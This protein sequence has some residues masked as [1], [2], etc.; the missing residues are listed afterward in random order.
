MSIRAEK[1]L[2]TLWRRVS[3]RDEG[4][5]AL[6]IVIVVIV[7][8]TGFSVALANQSDEQAPISTQSVLGRLALQ[9][10]Q[11]GLADYQDFI[12]ANPLNAGS[13][14]SNSTFSC[15]QQSTTVTS[16]SVPG[17]ITVG[18]TTGFNL[19]YLIS[20]TTT[21]GSQM[22]VSCTGS[23]TTTFTGCTGNETT[24]I[25]ASSA[26]L[27]DETPG[28]EDPAFVSAFTATPSCTANT[29]SNQWSTATVSN[30]AGTQAAYQ[31]VV[32]SSALYSSTSG[33]T[34]SG[35]E[36]YVY[37]TG[38]AGHSGDYRCASVQGS[39]WVQLAEPGQA[40]TVVTDDNYTAID[41]PSGSCGANC[42][43][44]TVTFTVSGAQGGNGGTGFLGTGGKGGFGEEIEG[45]F[46]I[47]SSTQLGTD[48]GY[49]G[50]MAGNNVDSTTT[51]ASGSNNVSL[52]ANTID[53]ASTS[54]FTMPLP[55]YVTTTSNNATTQQLVTCDRKLSSTAFTNCSGGAGT[56][57]TGGAVTQ[58]WSTGYGN[59]GASGNPG[60]SYSYGGGYSSSGSGGA[61]SAVCLEPLT[62]GSCT[63]ST[64][65][66]NGA[67]TSVPAAPGCVL[68]VAAG[69]GGAGEGTSGGSAGNGGNGGGEQVAFSS[70][71]TPT[72]S[73]ATAEA[74]ADV[75]SSGGDGYSFFG[76]NTTA[77]GGGKWTPAGPSETGGSR[78]TGESIFGDTT[79]DGSP[80]Q[81]N[82]G[83]SGA[84]VT[85]TGAT[86]AENG[87]NGPAFSG[88]G[89]FWWCTGSDGGGGGGGLAGGGSGAA[90]GDGGAGAGAGA[91]SWFDAGAICSSST[92]GATN[93][94]KC[95]NYSA[96]CN[97]GSCL[98][99]GTS[100]SG[101]NG[102]YIY[103]GIENIVGGSTI[104]TSTTQCLNSGGGN[105]YTACSPPFASYPNWYTGSS[106]TVCGGSCVHYGTPET[107][108]ASGSN[109]LTL[110]QS[111]IDVASTAGFNLQYPLDV[112]LNTG[113]Y[114][115]VNCTGTTGTTFT[116]CSGGSGK[117]DS[118]SGLNNV[119][120]DIGQLEACGSQFDTEAPPATTSGSI[121]MYGGGGG[122]AY[123]GGGA[124]GNGGA[125]TVNFVATAADWY[126]VELGCG[127]GGGG[128]SWK[129]G[130]A[131]GCTVGASG[132]CA[133]TTNGGGGGGGA[134]WLCFE[135]ASQT[136]CSVGTAEC[137]TSGALTAPCLLA[138]V[139]G[140]GG[141]GTGGGPGGGESSSTSTCTATAPVSCN[142]YPGY[143]GATESGAGAAGNSWFDSGNAV[144]GL[145]SVTADDNSP[146]DFPAWGTTP[147]FECTSSSTTVSA[148]FEE[149]VDN[150]QAGSA[151]TVPTT[152]EAG[153]G[154]G[155]YDPTG[156][157]S[158][159]AGF[160]GYGGQLGLVV[161][162]GEYP[163]VANYGWTFWTVST[164][165]LESGAC[166]Y[167]PSA[168]STYLDNDN[169][170]DSTTVTLPNSGTYTLGVG[171]GAGAN[172]W[173]TAGSGDFGTG[174]SG[175][176]L[177]FRVPGLSAG[178]QLTVVAG[179]AGFGPL[180]GIGFSDGGSSGFQPQGQVAPTNTIN[181]T[182]FLNGVGGG[183]GGSSA[184][185]L[186]PSG[187]SNPT[188]TENT[189]LCT[190][191]SPTTTCLIALAGGGG[192]GGTEC[193]AQCSTT[194]PPVL[195]LS[196]DC[197]TT[198]PDLAGEG[199]SSAT[200]ATNWTGYWDGTSYS[201]NGPGTSYTGAAGGGGGATS[202]APQSYDGDNTYP[203]SPSG[204]NPQN[205]GNGGWYAGPGYPN[206][207]STTLGGIG[208]GGGGAGF[209]GGWADAWAATTSGPSVPTD[210]NPG[211]TSGSNAYLTTGSAAECGAGGGSS[212]VAG[213]VSNTVAGSNSQ[214]N[215]TIQVFFDPPGQSQPTA[216]S[217]VPVYSTTW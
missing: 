139:G 96:S 121:Y 71:A 216:T 208:A 201:A 112:Q 157:G 182:P 64:P 158:A 94:S 5:Q 99:I 106:H 70:S 215:G 13:F 108:I 132:S 202:G 86:V 168:S 192:G 194:T 61:G 111:T 175:S 21:S 69:G 217:Q 134:S 66:C 190:T 41:V 181:F 213:I 211:A 74:D 36:V 38:R 56:M 133:A 176:E 150:G 34:P 184:I 187:V 162:S 104:P 62:G 126:G 117:L 169:S 73:P 72:T 47:P 161:V 165:A 9:A 210:A 54:G 115:E 11:A 103:G 14:C 76:Q 129:G 148:D 60:G 43:S 119:F 123:N 125:A 17:T 147:K 145:T 100:S 185:C 152:G 88:D 20:V 6:A 37:A 203:D 207:V 116:G 93:A 82:S 120:E 89:C 22:S 140:G 163:Y 75:G 197:T 81:P 177:T 91:A 18:S 153:A 79:P 143:K 156:T 30:V 186:S 2:R 144:Y 196:T 212:W 49:Q 128:T 172:G 137:S 198:S 25:L 12:S 160:G 10:A 40:Q 199:L 42:S 7:L 195:N 107:T 164:P 98:Q 59:G 151:T 51:I 16:G 55:I 35:G 63:S 19:S 4:G 45:T 204:G 102:S 87:A 27:Q 214:T 149:S 122:G 155:G 130:A 191:N 167:T 205:G 50:V 24:S 58:A 39:F 48:L 183:G 90:G 97:T 166:N 3:R 84:T 29:T 92:V 193:A 159:G 127:G 80:G 105:A 154:C 110:P 67:V 174:G 15:H 171:G 78:G 31:Y 113:G 178:Q 77:A 53:V 46:V 95:P 101:G 114:T 173:Q 135:G 32:N 65:L 142:G 33:S 57:S 44:T 189:P 179:C 23:T 83:T 209:E 52:P 26:A 118:A 8:L 68:V 136:S 85:I 131:N 200:G 124:G 28:G 146:T 141:G 206:S 188:C 109:G 138:V 1:I 180:G 170:P